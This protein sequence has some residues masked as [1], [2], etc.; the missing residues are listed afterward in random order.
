MSEPMNRKCQ[1]KQFDP[2]SCTKI[3]S[4][5]QTHAAVLIFLVNTT[6]TCSALIENS[7]IA[8]DYSIKLTNLTS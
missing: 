2:L 6:M 7:T 5:N 3:K 8:N 1:P 4:Q